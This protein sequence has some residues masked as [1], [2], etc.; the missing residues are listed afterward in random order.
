MIKHCSN[1]NCRAAFKVFSGAH[2]YGYERQSANTEFFW[3]CSA[4]VTKLALYLDP[5][6]SVSVRPWSDIS[7]VQPPHP[8]GNLRF[9]SRIMRP[10]PICFAIVARSTAEVALTEDEKTRVCDSAFLA[11]RDYLNRTEIMRHPG[12]FVGIPQRDLPGEHLI[13]QKNTAIVMMSLRFLR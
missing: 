7:R 9:I 4:C 12:R 6:G 3:L 8:D 10:R 2:I 13:G 1:P 5:A 11:E